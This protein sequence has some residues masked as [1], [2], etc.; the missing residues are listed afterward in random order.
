MILDFL[1]YLR[2][3]SSGETIYGYNCLKFDVPF[4]VA[5]LT[6]NNAMNGNIYVLLHDKKW[7]DLY[8]YQGDE[9]IS[10]NRWLEAYNIE[11]LSPYEG[12]DV[13]SLFLNG[14]YEDIVE[15]AVDDL[16]C[17]EKLVNVLKEHHSIL[18]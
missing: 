3:V 4:L 11:R 17:C 15:H 14:R 12:R 9:Y 6:V 10:M 7:F 2:H 18:K 13:P 1:E 16:I 5:R 8:Q